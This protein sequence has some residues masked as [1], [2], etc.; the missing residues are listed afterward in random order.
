MGAPVVHIAQPQ[1]CSGVE[2]MSVA[3]FAREIG[4]QG[5]GEYWVPAIDCLL[6]CQVVTGVLRASPN[7]VCAA[8]C[9][10]REYRVQ[11]SGMCMSR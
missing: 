4:E 5:L 2:S 9:A 3:C 1:H 7:T 8:G 10:Q 6:V 11:V